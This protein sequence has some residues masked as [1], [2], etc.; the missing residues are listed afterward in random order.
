MEG[1]EG[2][3]RER[4]RKGEGR[5]GSCFLAVRGM[6]APDRGLNLPS[7]TWENINFPVA[8][9]A[10]SKIMYHLCLYRDM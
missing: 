2:R 4:R 10:N 5:G 8:Y 7:L 9:T 1:E 6:N 3:A